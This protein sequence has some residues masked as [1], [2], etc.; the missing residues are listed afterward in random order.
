[1][2]AQISLIRYF[3]ACPVTLTRVHRGP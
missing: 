2:E 1:M 3:F